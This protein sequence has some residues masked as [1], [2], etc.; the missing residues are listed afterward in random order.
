MKSVM[1]K[2]SCLFFTFCLSL[3]VCF[4]Q[5]EWKQRVN[6]EG[7]TV[8][9]K[10]APGSKLNIIK[11]ECSITATLSQL[12]ATI[13]DVNSGSQWLYSTKSC[14]LVK[15]VSPAELYYYSEISFPWP[16]TNRDFV[17]HM[18]VTQNL[19]TKTVT[20]NAANIEGMIPVKPGIVRM[21]HSVGQWNIFPKEKNTLIIEYVLQADPGGSLPSWLTTIFD[22]KGPFETFKKLREQIQKPQYVSAHLPF[23]VN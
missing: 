15:Q 16:A 1:Y 23:I 22:T 6:K 19:S 13:L 17:A 4:A 14:S 9:S 8:F 5:N 20:I 18:S 2:I 3:S 7:I 21:L 11:V 12:V 10:Q